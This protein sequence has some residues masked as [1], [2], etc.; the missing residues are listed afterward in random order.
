M[1]QTSIL[2]IDDEPGIR[3]GCRRA[4]TP[5]GHQVESAENG[6]E[7]MQKVKGGHFDLALIDIMMPGTSGI[8]LIELIHQHDPDLVCIIITGYATVELAVRAIKQGAYDFLTKP[9]TTDELNLVVNQGLE[10]RRLTLEAKR[11]QEVEAEARRLAEEK[12]RLE[13]LDRAKAAFMLLVTHELQ[14]PITSIITNLDLLLNDYIPSEQ[15]HAYLEK[16]QARALEQK[17]LVAD[18]LEYAKL[19]ELKQFEELGQVQV[20][21]VLQAALGRLEGQ[22]GQKQ[23]KI[24]LE[25]GE[26]LSPVRIAVDQMRSVWLNLVSNAIKYTPSAGS[27]HISVQQEGDQILGQVKDTGIGIPEEA[28]QYLFS[29]FFRARN[30]KDLNIPGTGLGL[31][32]VKQILTKAGGKIW[33]E[34]KVNE[35]STFSFSLP[36]APTRS[37]K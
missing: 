36:T 18:L 31:A 10:R 11:L 34:S 35:G 16:I 25:I 17:D 14:A 4:L 6:E 30:A 23:V 2:V 5:L 27:I 24:T 32:I 37:A 3:E 22:A 8:D 9:F 7:A 12:A 21:D 33:V 19:K 1:D 20:E 13:E 28:C 15:H 26:Q 29:E